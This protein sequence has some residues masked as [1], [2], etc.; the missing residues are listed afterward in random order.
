[1]VET[2]A[3][4]FAPIALLIPPYK[5]ERDPMPLEQNLL[6]N[7]DMT[8][9]TYLRPTGF[10]IPAQPRPADSPG[11]VICSAGRD[12]LACWAVEVIARSG[13]AR[14][15]SYTMSAAGLRAWAADGAAE[16]AFA[17]LLDRH[18]APRAP[19][20][21][22]PLDRPVIMGIVNVTPDSFSDGGRTSSTD[23]AIAHALHL[24][25]DGADILDIGGESTRPGA[26]AITVEEELRRVIP[27]IEGLVGKTT[28]LI[29][30]DTRKAEVMRRALAAG[31]RIINDVAA[32]TYEPACMDVAAA[33]DAPIVLMHAQGD[34]R[35]MQAAPRYDECLL[36]V[37]DWLAARI[38]ACTAAGIDRARLIVDPGIGFGKTPDHNLELLAG[39]SVFQGLGVPVL[40]GASRKSFIGTLTGVK[41]ASERVAGSVAAALHGAAQGV[42]ILR[43]H[44]VA[45]TRQALA[46]WQAM[47]RDSSVPSPR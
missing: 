5:G 28:T 2:A 36:D 38:D 35:T 43:V 41:V 30:I 11:D 10:A 6:Y 37:Y 29:S 9:R 42:Q 7:I 46:V 16:G 19:L 23:A 1:L 8:L 26:Q 15:L 18:E 14:D 34:P 22:L 44:D 20:A 17:A 39:L 32:L 21:G 25:A 40:L 47:R 4:R 31:A 12:D 24:A 45:E 13:P 27:V 33:S 3:E